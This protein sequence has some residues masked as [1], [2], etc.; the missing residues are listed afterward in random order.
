MMLLF[1][2]LILKIR[3]ALMIREIIFTGPEII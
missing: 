1:R 3:Q 2:K